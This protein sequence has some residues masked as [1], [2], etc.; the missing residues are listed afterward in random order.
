MR[1]QKYLHVYAEMEPCCR[2]VLVASCSART[3][4]TSPWAA[5]ISSTPGPAAGDLGVK[6]SSWLIWLKLHDQTK[7]L[8]YALA[9]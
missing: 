7:Q 8:A 3:W 5:V 2:R 1:F 4:P 6:R 9:H